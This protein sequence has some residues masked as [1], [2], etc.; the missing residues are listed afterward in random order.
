M[1]SMLHRVALVTSIAAL[2]ATAMLPTSAPALASAAPE[3]CGPNLVTNGSFEQG[4][5][6]GRWT[7]MPTG[8][9]AITGWTVTKGTVDIVGTLW[10]ASDGTTSVDLDGVS[11]GGISQTIA[12]EAGKTYAATF[13]LA[14]NPF[15][16]PTI[17]RLLISAAGQSAQFASDM[18][19]RTS[20]GLGW[21]TQSWQFVAKTTST[22]LA[23]DSLDTEN[24]YFGAVIDNVRVQTTCER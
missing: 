15:G 17:K 10:K 1:A 7:T 21:Q 20:A 23:F 2:V 4:P 8:S 11:F 18:R 14:A 9:T 12:T 16:P 24:G 19:Q 6:P 22:T 13:D 3:P 5:P